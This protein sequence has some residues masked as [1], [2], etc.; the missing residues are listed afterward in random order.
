MHNG[1][2]AKILSLH[3]GLRNQVQVKLAFTLKLAPSTEV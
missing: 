1:V 3:N 2:L